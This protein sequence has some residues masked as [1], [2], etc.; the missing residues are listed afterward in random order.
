MTIAS[1]LRA[2][3][4]ASSIDQPDTS[5]VR[6]AQVDLRL[7]KLLPPADAAPRTLT[8]AVRDIC[9]RPG[10]RVRPLLAMLSS[11]HFGGRELAALDFGC[12]AWTTP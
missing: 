9:L 3:N 8:G 7:K 1:V 12:P 10:K 5:A 4:S 2:S 11:A 6:R